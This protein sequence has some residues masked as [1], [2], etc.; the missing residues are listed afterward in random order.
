[1]EKWHQRLRVTLPFCTCSFSQSDSFF[2]FSKANVPLICPQNDFNRASVHPFNVK[3]FKAGF[4]CT[5]NLISDATFNVWSRCVKIWSYS[6]DGGDGNENVKSS[7]DPIATLFLS[8]WK[9]VPK[10]P[11]QKFNILETIENVWK[12]LIAENVFT[13]NQIH[14]PQWRIQGRGPGGRSP[15]PSPPYF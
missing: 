3:C 8:F 12:N 2:R 15:P 5:Q 1:M 10:R 13:H 7:C 6:N 4:C 14:Y 9:N 11:A